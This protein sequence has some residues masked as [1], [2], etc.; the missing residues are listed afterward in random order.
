MN[1][2]QYLL[3]IEELILL[4]NN[5]LK[6]DLKVKFTGYSFNQDESFESDLICNRCNV[7]FELDIAEN[8]NYYNN[9]Y[10]N[11]ISFDFTS[12]K[13]FNNG[14]HRDEE[15]DCMVI[16]CNELIVKGIIE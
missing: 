4:L 11:R 9:S 14:I 12:I 2:L 5:E 7:E 15:N 8:V 3:L 1:K 10:D 16:P 13:L 6:H